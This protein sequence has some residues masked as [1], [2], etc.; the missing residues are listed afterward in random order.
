[1]NRARLEHGLTVIRKLSDEGVEED[2]RLFMGSWGS[3]SACGSIGGTAP[4]TLGC[5]T[6]ACLA[7][8][9][10]LDPVFREQGLCND[11]DTHPHHRF[12]SLGPVFG[13]HREYRALQAFFD[14]DAIACNHIFAG[15][16]SNRLEDAAARIRF[17][18]EG[19]DVFELREQRQAQRG[20]DDE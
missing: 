7:G 9:F 14:L 4:P 18:L 1:M 8:W 11:G 19:R 13:P 2:N 5:Y 16:N 6:S 17:V 3:T 12:H 10:T 20:F 15:W